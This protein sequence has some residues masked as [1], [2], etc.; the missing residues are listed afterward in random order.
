MEKIKCIKDKCGSLIPINKITYINEENFWVS[1]GEERRD[2][3]Y[4]TLELLLGI[5]EEVRK[6]RTPVIEERRSPS[7][8][9]DTDTCWDDDNF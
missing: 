8:E 6:E 7:S 3:S 9:I 2:I 5:F 1:T 4:R